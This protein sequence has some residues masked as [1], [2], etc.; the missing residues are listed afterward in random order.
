MDKEKVIELLTQIQESDGNVLGLR[1]ADVWLS[2]LGLLTENYLHGAMKVIRIMD[3]G[4]RSVEVD[5]NKVENKLKLYVYLSWWSYMFRRKKIYNKL[6]I[7][8]ENNFSKQDVDVL[9]EKFGTRAH[10]ERNQ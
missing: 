3:N 9:F 7:F 5:Y 6:V 8:S 1:T 4:I 10:Y 2:D